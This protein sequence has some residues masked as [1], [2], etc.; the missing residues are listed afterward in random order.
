MPRR[1]TPPPGTRVRGLLDSESGGHIW[2][3]HNDKVMDAI[4]ALIV[5][6][7]EGAVP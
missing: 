2:V 7:G 1:N 5:P 4:T 6:L 3:G